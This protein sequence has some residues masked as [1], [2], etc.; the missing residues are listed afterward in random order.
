MTNPS[1]VELVNE[2]R[3]HSHLYYNLSRPGISDAQFDA[4]VS[5]IAAY[6]RRHPSEILPDSPTQSVGIDLAS[7]MRSVPHRTPMLSQQKAHDIAEILAF[8]SKASASEMLVEWKLDGISLSLV[9]IDGALVSAATRGN[10]SCG[11]P[12]LGHAMHMQGVPATI[13]RKGRVEVRGEVVCPKGEHAP[14]G[15]ADERTAAS[16]ICNTPSYQSLA[17]SLVFVAWECLAP[18]IASFADGRAELSAL[19]FTVSPARIATPST[20]ASI[21]A[22]F[23]P[24]RASLPWAV[25]GLVIKVNDRALFDSLGS[26]SHHPKGSIAY[27]FA[28]A[29][30]VTT[31]RTIEMSVGRTGRRTPVAHIDPVEINGRTIAKVNLYTEKTMTALGVAPGAQVR[32]ILQNDVT[33]KIA[34]VLQDQPIT[35]IQLLPPINP[36]NPIPPTTT[37]ETPA[38]VEESLDDFIARINADAPAPDTTSPEE[39]EAWIRSEIEIREQERAAMEAAAAQY[40]LDQQAKAEARAAATEAYRRRCAEQQRIEAEAQA[41]ADREQE[42]ASRVPWWAKAIAAVLALAAVSLVSALAAGLS[43]F[44]LPLL[45]G[46]YKANLIPS[47]HE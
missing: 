15:Y 32:V 13:A 10:G 30:A 44:F 8:A 12:V 19:G 20:I 9:Y 2:A 5:R 47:G 4:L 35:P 7:G 11:Q 16:A 26:T 24:E 17:S 45:C 34:A 18:G 31:V 42:E 29:G 39:Y 37:E 38:E 25:D 33:P 6:E 21:I 27:K 14:L 28:A 3:Y 40:R 41:A 43:V 46:A 36:I 22:G 23:E 1:Y